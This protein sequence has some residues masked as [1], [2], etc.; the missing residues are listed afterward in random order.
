MDIQYLLSA[1]HVGVVEHDAAVEATGTQ[2]GGVENVGTVCGSYEDDVGVDIEAVHLDKYLIQGLLALVV[3]AAKS[4]ASMSSHRVYLIHEDDA[5][6][7]ALRLLE[8]IA[9]AARAHAN[10][11][12][13]EL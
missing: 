10:E 2:Q 12:F 3:A 9:H 5:G 8:E 6:R 11:H 7:V 4:G 13:Y 1:A